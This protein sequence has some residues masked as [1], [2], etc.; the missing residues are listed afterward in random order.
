MYVSTRATGNKVMSTA[1]NKFTDLHPKYAK[2]D[3]VLNILQILWF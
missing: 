1:D 3:L 2:L